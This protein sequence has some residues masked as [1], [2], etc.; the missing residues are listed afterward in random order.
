MR[1][2][3]FCVWAD[4]LPPMEEENY[5]SKVICGECRKSAIMNFRRIAVQS[6]SWELA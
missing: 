6:F 5:P 2:V 4:P 1:V 3:W